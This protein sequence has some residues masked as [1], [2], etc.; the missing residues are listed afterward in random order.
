M[1]FVTGALLGA[2]TMCVF[3]SPASAFDPERCARVRSA[4][5]ATLAG[6]LRVAVDETTDAQE[7]YARIAFLRLRLLTPDDFA[8]DRFAEVFR[9]YAG[10]EPL[11]AD[12]PY[13]APVLARLAD[14]L[15]KA[16]PA[17]HT[18]TLRRRA[19]AFVPTSSADL[20]LLAERVRVGRADGDTPVASTAGILEVAAAEG[21]MD[22]GAL[23]PGAADPEFFGRLSS[24]AH[25]PRNTPV[26]HPRA[27]ERSAVLMQRARLLQKD[28]CLPAGTVRDPDVQRNRSEMGPSMCI[29]RMTLNEGSIDWE[30][31]SIRNAAHPDGP[32]WYLPHDDEN[33]AFDAAVYAVRRYGGRLVAVA[34]TE[35]RNYR[36][37]DPNRYF[38]ASAAAAR[39]CAISAGTPTYTGF[40]M[41]LFDGARHILSM[42]NNTR[43]GALSVKVWDQKTKGYPVNGGPYA[44]YDHFV[45]IAGGTPL[46]EDAEAKTQRNLFISLGL[47]V[48]H[49]YV[50]ANN[51]DCSLS[52]YVVLNDERRYYNIEAVHGSTIQK[53]MVAAFVGALGYEAIPGE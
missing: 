46:D 49:E 26:R 35:T 37:V 6:A 34:G 18:D 5:N 48:V 40:V 52:N 43:G 10:S 38:A 30:F 9:T 25:M 14:S 50:S 28:G 47:N 16:E 17:V 2:V 39:P 45:L 4:D 19:V 20:V 23:P 13:P 53:A 32:V 36:G 15:L 44:D 22:V 29:E 51:N 8:S 21:T 12:D 42:H 33:E 31:V 41:N 27:L 1:R 24:D 11:T 7:C 3:A